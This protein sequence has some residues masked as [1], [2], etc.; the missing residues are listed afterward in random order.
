MKIVINTDFGGFSISPAAIEALAKL[1]CRPCYFFRRESF[2]GD[3]LFGAPCEAPKVGESVLQWSVFDIPN[4]DEVLPPLKDFSAADLEGRKRHNAAWAF[5]AHSDRPE[6]RADPHLVSVVEEL[7]E[8]ANGAH[9]KLKV[10]EIPDGV[11]WE[12][13]DYGGKESVHEKHRSWR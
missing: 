4:P 5:H 7:G 9:A 13:E 1:K 10:V 3:V 6:D 12:I 8:A 2:P 11:A